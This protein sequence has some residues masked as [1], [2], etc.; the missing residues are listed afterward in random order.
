MPIIGS[1]PKKQVYVPQALFVVLVSMACALG[2]GIGQMDIISVHNVSD[3]QHSDLASVV[4]VVTIIWSIFS[5]V[6]KVH[7]EKLENKN[8]LIEHE[9]AARKDLENELSEL[10]DIFREIT[11]HVSE[12][13]WV[14]D[15]SSFN[16][17]YV[18]PSFEAIWCRPYNEVFCEGISSFLKTIHEDDRPALLSALDEYK[19]GRSEEFIYR[20][21]R[22]DGCVRWIEERG[23]PVHGPNG[24]I[25]RIVGV[26][27]DITD[28]RKS[29]WDCRRSEAK[30]K[31]MYEQAPIGIIEVDS[32]GIFI[33]VNRRFC[34]IVGYVESEIIGRPIADI[35]HPDDTLS[36]HEMFDL[37]RDKNQKIGQFKQRF[38]HKNGS[39]RV[40][41][42]YCQALSDEN[43]TISSIMGIVE[44]L[45]EATRKEREHQALFEKLQASEAKYRQ[46]AN[47]MPQIVWTTLPDGTIDYW[48]DRAHEAVGLTYDFSLGVLWNDYIHPDDRAGVRAAWQKSLEDKKR[49]EAEFRYGANSSFRWYLSQAIPVFDERG[50][51]TKWFGSTT[52]ITTLKNTEAALKKSENL[53]RRMMD[54]SPVGIFF[55]QGSRIFEMNNAFAEIAGVSQ[56]G[57]L[58][59]ETL[60]SLLEG[61]SS[62]GKIYV[63][64]VNRCLK[65]PN[66]EMRHV[67]FSYSS[68]DPK[69]S[70]GVG[71]VV[72]IHTQILMAEELNKARDAAESANASKSAFLANVSHEIRTPLGAILGFAELLRDKDT[73][74]GEKEKYIEI[75]SRNGQ[76]LTTIINDILDFSKIEAGL[77]TIETLSVSIQSL[78][79]ESISLFR[80]LAMEKGLGLLAK[81]KEP[82][83]QYVG[84]DPTRLKQILINLIGNAIKFTEQGSVTVSA[85]YHMRKGQSGRLIVEVTDTGI[86]IS[87]RHKSR[88]FKPFSQADES[89]VRK[90]GG[91]GLGLALSKKL[92]RA[93]G[94][95]VALA[96][97]APGSG[98]VFRVEIEDRIAKEYCKTLPPAISLKSDIDL[99][100]VRVLLVDDSSDN[101][102][103]VSTIL[104]R[105]HAQ[106]SVASNG[107]E[108]VDKAMNGLP[109]VIIMDVEMPIM[110]GYTAVRVLRAK[111]F[112]K[113][114]I[115]STAHAMAGI[116]DRCLEAGYTDYLVKPIQAL[117]LIEKVFSY[118]PPVLML[119]DEVMNQDSSK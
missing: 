73:E 113:P 115:A 77:L 17:V 79:E 56:N 59:L 92:A 3:W 32:T 7:R 46:L 38:V 25:T 8:S 119:R 78:I 94:G 2:F 6:L 40:A 117:S 11:G 23:F 98:S 66:G 118:A 50:I 93:L 5:I 67:L 70:T 62:D 14:L 58:P 83:P 12:V 53:L 42:L 19:R 34:D 45:T 41:S 95:E 109:D 87:D 57:E 86:G 55:C 44:D 63:R 82:L 99:S 110:D 81:F 90:F 97:S 33:K 1:I 13:F 114:I 35:T 102:Q 64:P 24:D 9:K 36:I 88:L 61:E 43:G 69:E 49:Y 51:L 15:L 75:I 91:T 10:R 68:L 16:N 104:S 22:P 89:I 28:R 111:G 106:V 47:C 107:L 103:L 116:H 100:H 96:S 21:V 30:L 72:D 52:D 65:K 48:N 18:S 105:H 27:E 112:K 76:Q 85:S 101:L 80:A 60:Q 84:T 29:D 4:L 108:G 20:V 71:F 39:V 37:I 74:D 31:A 54:I 26:A